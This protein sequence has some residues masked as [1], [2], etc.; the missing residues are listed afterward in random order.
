[1]SVQRTPLKVVRANAAT[2]VLIVERNDC[3]LQQYRDMA[4]FRN[5]EVFCVKKI[6]E[7]KVFLCKNPERANLRFVLIGNPQGSEPGQVGELAKYISAEY[8]LKAIIAAW[9]SSHKQEHGLKAFYDALAI[10]Q[11]FLYRYQET[12]T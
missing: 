2:K 8:R 7:A 6:C 1:M 10:A 3:L 9:E 12:R 5:V 11:Y 4:R